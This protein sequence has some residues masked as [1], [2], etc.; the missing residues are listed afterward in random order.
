MSLPPEILGFK[1][2]K[3]ANIT[4]EERL[5][6]QTVIIYEQKFTLYEEAK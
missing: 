1:F 2:L 6:V 5:L 4:K 3:K